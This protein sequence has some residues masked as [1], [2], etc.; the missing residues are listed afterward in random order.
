MLTNNKN[1]LVKLIKEKLRY[2][3]YIDL[4]QL[5]LENLSKKLIIYFILLFLL[6][7]S[8]LYYTTSFCAVYRNSQK[9]WFLGCV[10]SFGMDSLVSFIICIFLALFKFNLC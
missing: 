5:K 2:K 1:E 4:V 6:T 3:S 8:F 9:Y 7:F 10:E